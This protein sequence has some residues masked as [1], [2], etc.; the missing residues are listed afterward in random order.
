MGSK[1][2]KYLLLKLL[3]INCSLNTENNWHTQKY[4]HKYTPWSSHMF[5]FCYYYH[6]LCANQSSIYIKAIL[7]QK[8]T[9]N[10]VWLGS[11]SPTEGNLGRA[12]SSAMR[13]WP[14]DLNQIPQC[15]SS[16]RE[17]LWPRNS[18]DIQTLFHILGLWNQL[19]YE[20]Q[21]L[22]LICSHMERLTIVLSIL[23]FFHLLLKGQQYRTKRWKNEQN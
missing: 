13:L 21:G 1:I 17:S 15:S 7:K 19:F 10:T 22:I 3:L 4:T 9:Y 18:L 20:G 11:L 5:P 16:S 23:F 2:K 8:S 14:M 12:R 6:L